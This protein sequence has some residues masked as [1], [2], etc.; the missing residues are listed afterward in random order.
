[1]SAPRAAAQLLRVR[2]A[3]RIFVPPATTRAGT[4]RRAIPTIA[5][6]TRSRRSQS[7][8]VVLA[9]CSCGYSRLRNRWEFQGAAVSCRQELR[10]PDRYFGQGVPEL[11]ERCAAPPP[12]LPREPV[13][14]TAKA[15]SDG[16]S[17]N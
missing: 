6:S 13:S 1:M 11:I 3:A 17:D 5:L 15:V 2:S 10:L 7:V 9:N 4:A 8:S 14:P 12:G 16:S